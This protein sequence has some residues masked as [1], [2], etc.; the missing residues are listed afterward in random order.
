MGVIEAHQHP[1]RI[2]SCATL[3]A[4]HVDDGDVWTLEL[5]GEA[6][7]ATL[8]MLTEELAEGVRVN[9]PRF[10]IDMAGLRFCDVG[11]AELIMSVSRRSPVR[12]TR[13][14]GLVRRVF[15]LLDSEWYPSHALSV[16]TVDRPPRLGSSPGE[17]GWRSS[18]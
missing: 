2:R 18:W 10:I 11:S 15:D 8:P 13:V 3:W 4:G 14:T 12:L 6:D 5:S 17:D 1:P 9:R 7:I 16:A